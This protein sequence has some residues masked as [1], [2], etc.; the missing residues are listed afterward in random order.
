MTPPQHGSKSLMWCPW[1]ASSCTEAHAA[2]LVFDPLFA[3]AAPNR[4]WFARQGGLCSVP[5]WHPGCLVP[6]SMV[7]ALGLLWRGQGEIAEKQRNCVASW[8]VFAARCLCPLLFAGLVPLRILGYLLFLPSSPLPLLEDGPEV[9]SLSAPPNRA[10]CWDTGCQLGEKPEGSQRGDSRVL[11]NPAT[12][13][14][15]PFSSCRA[16]HGFYGLCGRILLRRC[17]PME[18]K[19]PSQPV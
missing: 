14:P 9:C 5:C 13:F 12:C 18:G 4:A 19:L 10:R 2:R 7:V 8:D 11:Y 3:Q 6:K 15:W 16:P 17:F 1:P